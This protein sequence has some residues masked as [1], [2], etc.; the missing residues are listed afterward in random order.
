LPHGLF[1]SAFHDRDAHL[2]LA[3][4]L[5]PLQS[6]QRPNV[7]QAAT[8]NYT[9]FNRRAGGVQGIFDTGLFLFAGRS[10]G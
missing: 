8:R 2:A 4:E 7:G 1:H 9:F 6:R 3:I 10:S 5:Q